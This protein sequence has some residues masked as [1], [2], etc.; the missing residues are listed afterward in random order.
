MEKYLITHG[1]DGERKKFDWAVM[2]DDGIKY[3]KRGFKTRKEARAYVE[4]TLN[5]TYSK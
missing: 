5:G 1:W 3:I 4:N 2:M